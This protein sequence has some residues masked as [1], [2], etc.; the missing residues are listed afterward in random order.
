MTEI[1]LVQLLKEKDEQA[2]KLLYKYYPKI[3]SYLRGFGASIQEVEDIYHESLYIMMNKL[4]DPQFE[5]TSSVNTFLFGICKNKYITL[6]REQKKKY[7]DDWIDNLTSETELN[8]DVQEA[9]KEDRK[10]ELA[11]K[12]LRQLEDR[13]RKLLNAFYVEKR[14]MKE[15]ALEFGFSSDRVAKTQKYRCLEA[16][17]KNYQRG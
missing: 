3:R 16:A 8:V 13:C 5:L 1:Q 2:F 4:D 15:I 9:L 7:D 14:R 10:Y 6:S 17:K 11:Q 12:A